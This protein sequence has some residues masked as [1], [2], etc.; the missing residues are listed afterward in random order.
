M[1]VAEA[2]FVLS[3]TLVAVTVTVC[4]ALIVAGA[5]YKPVLLIL[6][7]PLGLMLHVTAVFGVLITMVLNCCVCDA[8]SEAVVGVT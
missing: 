4:C 7:V 3:A 6:P 8:Y 2:L 1:I 5:V